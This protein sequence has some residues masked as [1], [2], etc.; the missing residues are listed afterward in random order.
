VSRALIETGELLRHGCTSIRCTEE[1]RGV[2][3]VAWD[4]IE[5]WRTWLEALGLEVPPDLNKR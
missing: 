1:D 5:P 4:G 2:V 3:D